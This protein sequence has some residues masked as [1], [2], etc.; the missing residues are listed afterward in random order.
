MCLDN[1][2]NSRV[3]GILNEVC[4]L[5]GKVQGGGWIVVTS[6]Q[7]QPH[8][9][10]RM[11]SEQNLVL[12]P[13]RAADAMVALWRQIQKIE[14]ADADDD[15]VLAEIEKLKWDDLDE[16]CALWKL[17]GD[18]S[19]HGL[20]GLPLALVQSGSFIAQFDH[21]LAGYLNLFETASKEEW[22]SIVNKTEDLKSIRE[23]QR[24]IWTTWKIRVQKLSA[25]AYK[26]LGAMAMLRQGGIEEEIAK[27]ILKAATTGEGGSVEIMFETVIVKELMHGSSLIWC[28]GGEREGS[29]VYRMHRL[30]RLFILKD[31]GRDVAI[32]NDAYRLA[33]FA[34]HRSVEIEL[35]KEGSSFNAFPHVFRN[36]HWGF[37]AH[38]LA[39]VHH[40]MLPVKGSEMRDVSEVEDIHCYSGR[41]M[42]FM[43]KSKE[44]VEV[45]EHLLEIF[46][47]QRA[48][49]RKTSYSK[50]LLDPW[51]HRNRR[52]KVERRITS[53]YSSLGLALMTA[54]KLDSAAS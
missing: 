39:L 6:R 29:W 9:R 54:G 10:S 14:I 49:N 32:R 19:E 11:K 47:Y 53:V 27:S 50:L 51:S 43:G 20:G 22:A 26:A 12:K 17:C 7:G 3:D 23:S 35:K 44:E 28:D 25:K 36:I 30:V 45:W 52:K 4:G 34:L 18:D 42:Q 8:I 16:Y 2:D 48:E 5:A 33:L 24:S 41:V 1:A 37:S 31:L 38:S 13:L 21:S 46:I 40:H 15:S